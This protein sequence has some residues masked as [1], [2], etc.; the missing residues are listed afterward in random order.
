MG[1][2][3]SSPPTGPRGRALLVMIQSGG[4]YAECENYGGDSTW[5]ITR[6]ERPRRWNV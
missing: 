4:Q 1:R 3:E 6:M 2:D 5:I